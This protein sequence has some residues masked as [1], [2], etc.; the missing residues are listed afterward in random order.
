MYKLVSLVVMSVG[1]VI[2]VVVKKK[3][4]EHAREVQ[5]LDNKVGEKHEQSN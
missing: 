4:Q 2:A 5:L 1:V 3:R